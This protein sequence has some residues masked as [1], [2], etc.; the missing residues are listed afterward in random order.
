MSRSQEECVGR[1]VCIGSAADLHQRV[2]DAWTW[3]SGIQIN[4]NDVHEEISQI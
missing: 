4:D 3:I 1:R 2:W